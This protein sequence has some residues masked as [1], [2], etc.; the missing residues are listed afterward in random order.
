MRREFQRAIKSKTIQRTQPH[1]TAAPAGISAVRPFRLQCHRNARS[2]GLVDVHEQKWRLSRKNHGGQNART[3]AQNRA[4]KE[5]IMR[6]IKWE[7]PP[8]SMRD[9]A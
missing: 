3:R 9:L 4:L 6:N 5:S 7:Q 1:Q 8:R 2:S